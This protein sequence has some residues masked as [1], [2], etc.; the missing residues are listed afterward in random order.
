M[1]VHDLCIGLYSPVDMIPQQQSNMNSCQVADDWNFS[2]K[3]HTK[4]LIVKT[5]WPH[6][7]GIW[8]W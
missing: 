1:H 5:S 6:K 8:S 3:L 7:E 2:D 4:P